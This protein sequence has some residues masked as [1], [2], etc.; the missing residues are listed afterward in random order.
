MATVV[1]CKKEPYDIYIGRPHKGLAGS[2]WQNPFEIDV[3]G[4]RERV[5]QLYEEYIRGSVRMQRFLPQLVGKRLGCWCAPKPC[6]GDVLCKLLV[7][8]GYE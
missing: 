7:E 4:D 5:I 8:F 3:D 1:H 6:H 2:I